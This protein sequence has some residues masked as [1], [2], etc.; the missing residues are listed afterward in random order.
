MAVTVTV[1][2]PVHVETELVVGTGVVE[3]AAQVDAVLH[4]VLVSAADGAGV[5]TDVRCTSTPVGLTLAEPVTVSEALVI[6]TEEGTLAAE[7]EDPVDAGTEVDDVE[8]AVV[9]PPV[10]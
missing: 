5:A 7:T 2:A 10:V 8:A 3:P 6:A 1:A 9:V 4:A